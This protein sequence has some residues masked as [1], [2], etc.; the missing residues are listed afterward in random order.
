[1]SPSRLWRGRPFWIR[2]ILPLGVAIAI[3]L[4]ADA[5]NANLSATVSLE[6]AVWTIA[7]VYALLVSGYAAWRAIRLL[8]WISG[9]RPASENA[10]ERIAAWGIVRDGAVRCLLVLV[11]AAIG[12]QALFVPPALPAVTDEAT[13]RARVGLLLLDAVIVWCAF[14]AQNERRALLR[15]ERAARP[16]VE[17]R[18]EGE[19][20]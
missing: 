8:V 1:M 7:N 19:T 17:L 12:I 3:V 2:S 16:L 13:H 4:L 6:E 15:L 5:N 9:H 20:A 10:L 18:E 11:F 14:D